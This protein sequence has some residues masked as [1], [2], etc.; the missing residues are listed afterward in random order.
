MG[1]SI[2]RDINAMIYPGAIKHGWEIPGL[3]EIVIGNL[4]INSGNSSKPWLITRKYD[5]YISPYGTGLF[6][7][8]T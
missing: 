4:S 6:H 3:N 2:Y 5:W 8:G 1:D 7:I